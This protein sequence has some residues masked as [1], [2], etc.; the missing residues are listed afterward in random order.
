MKEQE[1]KGACNERIVQIDCG[2]CTPLVFSIN[3]S[4][5]TECQ[6][7]Y[8]CLVQMISEKRDLQQSIS[9]NGIQKKACFGLLKSSLLCLRESR[10]ACRKRAE[11]KLTLMYLTLSPK[12]KLDDNQ[13]TATDTFE[14]FHS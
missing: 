14:I 13:K 11:L 10:I 8:L 2:T 5:G 7:L 9:S 1:K 4:M 6:K 3:G 12:Y